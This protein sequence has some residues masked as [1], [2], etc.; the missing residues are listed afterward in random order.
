MRQQG[1]L[2]AGLVEGFRFVV[3]IA[4]VVPPGVVAFRVL[5]AMYGVL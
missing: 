3:A 1:L 4:V 5:L 2:A